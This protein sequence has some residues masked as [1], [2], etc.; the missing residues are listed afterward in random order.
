MNFKEFPQL[1][2]SRLCLRKLEESDWECVSFLRSDKT[3]NHFVQ[4]P[5]ADTKEKA[6]QFIENINLKFKSNQILY[7]CISLEN[8]QRMIGSICLWNFSEDRKTAEIGYDL[9]PDFQNNGI[10]DES[11]K[12]VLSFGFSHLGLKKVEA[13]T[14]SKND[15]S[16]KL[17]RRNKFR[18]KEGRI[19]KDN[20]EIIIF[21]VDRPAMVQG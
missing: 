7:W 14:H 12:V 8:E 11:M 9:D 6:I 2:T 20:L 13:F 21:E 4:R 3:V 17:L 10:M 15:N 19:D 18:L 1:T 16:I 5:N